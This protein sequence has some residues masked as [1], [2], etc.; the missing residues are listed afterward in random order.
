MVH[1]CSNSKDVT[2]D[3]LEDPEIDLES[4]GL[5]GHDLCEAKEALEIATTFKRKNLLKEA[6]EEIAYQR[7]FSK[8]LADHLERLN[9]SAL[10]PTGLKIVAELR[11][12]LEKGSVSLLETD[13]VVKRFSKDTEEYIATIGFLALDDAHEFFA[14]QLTHPP[15][16]ISLADRIKK[17][18]L[19]D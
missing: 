10:N 7:E 12:L 1:V 8:K 2:I 19:E 18:M 13:K 4:Y 11:E 6:L 15:E 3:D 17:A 9:L 16:Y 14:L 5:E